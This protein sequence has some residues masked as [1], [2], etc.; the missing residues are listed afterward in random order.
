MELEI[1]NF[2]KPDETADLDGGRL[3]LL[4][5]GHV[6]VGR[7]TYPP[8]WVWSERVGARTNRRSCEV[9]HVVLV[10]SGRAV[11]SM[12][13]GREVTIGPGDLCAVPPGH[14]FEVLGD[15]PYASLHFHG[16]EEYGEASE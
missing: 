13:D 10:L 8:G 11:I 9:E 16:V 12:D 6:T 2:A 7:A 4:T 14:D 15:E 3:D 1:K 5:A